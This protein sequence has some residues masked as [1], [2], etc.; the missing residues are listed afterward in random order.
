MLGLIAQR[1]ADASRE[2]RSWVVQLRSAMH[3]TEKAEAQH[4]QA[5]IEVDAIA[6]DLQ[7]AAADPTG[8]VAEDLH[9]RQVLALARAQEAEE[10]A[11]RVWRRLHDDADRCAAALRSAA[12]DSMV[13]GAA[14][15][16]VRDTRAVVSGL[17]GVLGVAAAVPGPTQPF[18][19]AGAAA[20]G[21]G[22]VGIDLLLAVGFGD[23]TLWDVVK[24]STWVVGGAVAGPLAKAAG[25]GA[26]KVAGR[27]WV[28]TQMSARDRLAVVRQELTRDLAA[29]RAALRTPLADRRLQSTTAAAVGTRP[30]AARILDTIEDRM[31]AKAFAVN[32]RWRAAYANGPGAIALVH[33]AD[34]I[35]VAEAAKLTQDSTRA[36][37]DV[38]NSVARSR[39]DAVAAR[40]D[41]DR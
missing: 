6:R 31:M 9:R 11:G 1:Y 13:D 21:A 39:R 3:V 12:A 18:A 27:G 34:A 35:R 19:A 20:G 25:A 36:G 15:A 26:S 32:D 16:A 40:R 17:T 37:A 24:S 41:G 5:R 22:V 10:L 28:G 8:A 4:L 29:Q 7:G 38:A 14:Y 23:G 33:T 2:L 30:A